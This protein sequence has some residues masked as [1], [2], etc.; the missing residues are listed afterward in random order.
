[1]FG[2]NDRLKV[3]GPDRRVFKLPEVVFRL[4]KS[5]PEDNRLVG[6]TN[7]MCSTLGR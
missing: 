7:N 6:R 4:D 5:H 3:Q 1:M 2:M